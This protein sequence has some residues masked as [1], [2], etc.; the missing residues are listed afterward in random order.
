MLVFVLLLLYLSLDLWGWS[1]VHDVAAK[2]Q[3]VV[4]SIYLFFLTEPLSH[5]RLSSPRYR[6][7]QLI[8]A[9]PGS[10]LLILTLTL[11]PLCF[12]L[13]MQNGIRRDCGQKRFWF[14]RSILRSAFTNNRKKICKAT[15]RLHMTSYAKCYFFEK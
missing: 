2:F 11:S 3:I 13:S 14:L 8:I 4:V 12:F 6:T 9:T 10:S 7:C 15:K 5:C 1:G